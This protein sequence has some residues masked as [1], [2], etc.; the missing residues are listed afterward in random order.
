MILQLNISE[1]MENRV[2]FPLQDFSEPLTCLWNLEEVEP[3]LSPGNLF[4]YEALCTAPH[5]SG[6]LQ[7]TP[8]DT[9]AYQVPQDPIIHL[10]NLTIKFVP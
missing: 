5:W 7:G 3:V 9:Q 8:W 2:F 6:I 10:S 1:A 4:D